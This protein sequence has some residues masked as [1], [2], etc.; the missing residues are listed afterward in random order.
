MPAGAMVIYRQTAGGANLDV[1][2]WADLD[3]DTKVWIDGT[4]FRKVSPGIQLLEAG[5][6]LVL[7]ND[8]F[9]ISGTL[10][11]CLFETQLLLD[12]VA[13]DDSK[14]HGYIRGTQGCNEC[15][16]YNA[17]IINA[18]AD[19]VIKVQA[20]Q[21]VGTTASPTRMADIGS[22]QIIKLD[23]SWPYLKLNAYNARAIQD[24]GDTIS[25]WP[26]SAE[27]GDSDAYS[28]GDPGEDIVLADEGW[29]LVMMNLEYDNNSSPPAR[30]IVG[31]YLYNDTDA[32]DIPQSHT[33]SY[34]RALGGVNGV[35][36]GICLVKTTGD[37]Q[38]I[39]LVTTVAGGGATFGLGAEVYLSI[40]RLPDDIMKLDV[41][42]NQVETQSFDVSTVETPFEWNTQNEADDAY[43]HSTSVNPDNM[44]TEKVGP[45]LFTGNFL[46][47]YK[48]GTDRYNT[49]AKFRVG[50]T[51][52]K[53]GCFGDYV[54][55]AATVG[56]H[57]AA[58]GALMPWRSVDDIVELA[59]VDTGTSTGDAIYTVPG[60]MGVQ[61]IYLPSIF[62]G[63][64]Q[65]SW[66]EAW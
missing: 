61:S 31:A 49:L 65:G 52:L 50:G 26:Y 35:T 42:D 33:S 18:D 47:Y 15:F 8:G 48:T 62:P 32:A 10:D 57:G 9:E 53:Y 3:H 22:L 17:C 51:S 12:G 24:P 60:E 44:V 28:W 7:H 39:Q 29:Y 64:W 5:H 46:S 34:C 58:H 27:E 30:S 13:V 37:D 59:I 20:Q 66:V 55:Q 43:S 16:P 19:D 36:T 14:G 4:T 38:V 63:Y 6:Y 21:R 25:F 11:R 41:E 1:T 2:T 23:D 54:R 45:F 40:V 56:E